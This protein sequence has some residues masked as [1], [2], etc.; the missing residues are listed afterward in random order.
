MLPHKKAQEDL[1]HSMMQQMIQVMGKLQSFIEKMNT[2]LDN[3]ERSFFAKPQANPR[4][5]LNNSP[6]GSGNQEQ[7]KADTT[8]RSGKII[9]RESSP[10]IM[11]ENNNRESNRR[12]RR[13]G[14]Y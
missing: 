14:K 1:S 9:G 10:S 12:A 13:R 3:K 11:E 8:L 4:G 7:T 5:K 2:N 6:S